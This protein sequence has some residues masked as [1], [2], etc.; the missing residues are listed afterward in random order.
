M[1]PIAD[2]VPAECQ[3]PSH[4]DRLRVIRSTKAFGS[5]AVSLID[6]PAGAVFAP[7]TTASPGINAYSSVQTGPNTHIELNS[8]LLYINHSCDPSLVFDMKQ[9]QV[10]VADKRPLKAGDTLT[11]FYPSTEW[12]MAQPFQCTCGAGEKTCKG[13]IS[14]A[15][16]MSQEELEGYWLNDHIVALLQQ[17]DQEKKA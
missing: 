16:K 2:P 6:L 10:R 12:E 14:G 17:R 4:P 11:F 5:R 3:P 13:W 15:Q 1:A 8:D 9:M 7:I